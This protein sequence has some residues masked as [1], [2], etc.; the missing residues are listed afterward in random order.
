MKISVE[1]IKGIKIKRIWF[2]ND[3]KKID[4]KNCDLIYIY[5]YKSKVDAYNCFPQ[6]TLYL[7]L[8]KDEDQIFCEIRK[9]VKYEINRSYKENIKSKIYSSNELETNQEIIKKFE[10]KYNQ[11][12]KEK[13]LK[14]KLNLNTVNSYIKNNMFVLTESIQNEK[15]L[16][17]HAYVVNGENA[18]LLYSCS[19][20]RSNSKD[21]KNLIARANKFLHWEDIKYFKNNNYKVY[22]FGGITSF[23]NPNGIDKFKMSFNGNREDYY[24]IVIPVTIKGKLSLIIKKIFKKR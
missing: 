20:F 9:N 8:L 14:N 2:L 1:N 13:G 11:M 21:D 24:N 23:E 18:R 12:Y 19:N 5:G 7:E 17:Y 16:S 22:D 6:T 4:K 3:I 15:E 10:E